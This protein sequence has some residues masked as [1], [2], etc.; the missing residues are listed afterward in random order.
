MLANLDAEP[1]FDELFLEA[2]QRI[3][4]RG[5]TLHVLNDY[6]LFQAVEELEIAVVDEDNL[7]ALLVGE[8][9][10]RLEISDL[11]A[12]LQQPQMAVTGGFFL[13]VEPDAVHGRGGVAVLLGFRGRPIFFGDDDAHALPSAIVATIPQSARQARSPSAMNIAKLMLRM[14]A[15]AARI[16]HAR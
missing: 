8:A 6:F 11:S 10:L 13:A 16:T 1:G 14:T 9:R 4:R 12:F 2:I 7:N 5:R 3:L 15:A